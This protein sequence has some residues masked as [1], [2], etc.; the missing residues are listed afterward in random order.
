MPNTAIIALRTGF[1][2]VVLIAMPVL[3][4]PSVNRRVNGLL[5]DEMLERRPKPTA[6]GV[7][8]D[9]AEALQQQPTTANMV[10]RRDP[11]PIGD[12]LLQLRA[13]LEQLGADYMLLEASSELEPRYRFRCR[14]R[15]PGSPNN[16]RTFESTEMDPVRAM[17][18]GVAQ[19]QAWR[20]NYRR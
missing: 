20:S 14:M 1:V 17:A 10:Q 12:R 5:R 15:I 16:T 18:N 11:Q 13:E 3:A 8:T 7:G 19:V 6:T 9:D 4:I 2:F